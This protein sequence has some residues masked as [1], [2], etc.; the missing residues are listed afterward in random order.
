MSDT[1]EIYEYNTDDI[2]KEYKSKKTP[3][4]RVNEDINNKLNELNIKIKKLEELEINRKNRIEERLKLKEE[5]LKIKDEQKQLKIKEQEEKRKLKDIENEN[6]I[7]ELIE[8]ATNNLIS[9]KINNIDI[10]KED[11]NKFHINKHANLRRL[12]LNF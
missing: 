5:K 4:K 10:I 6:K 11:I 12:N 7:K 1:N 2:L 9:K 3:K 8:Q